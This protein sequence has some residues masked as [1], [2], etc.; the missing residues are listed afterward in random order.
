MRTAIAVVLVLV[1]AAS[2]AAQSTTIDTGPATSVQ[3]PLPPDT[4]TQKAQTPAESAHVSDS[5]TT[6]GYHGTAD[7]AALAG[8][9]LCGFRNIIGAGNSSRCNPGLLLI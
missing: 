9:A 4:A 3:V 8:R 7:A 6:R 1:G 2:A 5:T